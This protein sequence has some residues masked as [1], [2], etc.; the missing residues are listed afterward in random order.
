MATVTSSKR[1]LTHTSNTYES[2]GDVTIGG[3]LNINGTTTTIDTANL[4]VEDK[5]I[6]IGDV[7]SPSDTTADGGGIT[8]KGASDKTINWVN[9]TDSWTSN[10]RF[11]APNLTLTGL[12]AQNSEATALVVNGS[13]TVGTR[14]LGS[15][16]FNSTSFLTGNQTITLSGD[17]S[18]S[19][20]TSISVTVADDSHNHV[21]SNVDGLQSALDGKLGSSEKAAD[22]NLLDGIDSSAFLRS[23]A[24]DTATGQLTF[25][26][27]IIASEGL[28]GATGNSAPDRRIW[29]VSTT[30]NDWGIFY[31]EGN[32]DAIEFKSSGNVNAKIN[33]D[34]GK[35]Y[36]EGSNLVWHGGNDGSG[37][38]LDADLLDG[39]QG[40]KFLKSTTNPNTAGSGMADTTLSIGDSGS[41]YAFVQSH[42]GK[43]LRLNPAGN[44]VTIGSSN[45]TAWHSANDGSGS[46]LDADKLDGLHASS[47]AT[48][49]QGTKADNAL[50]KAGGTVTGDLTVNGKTILGNALSDK[51]VVH[52]HLGIGEDAY[53]KIAY[54]GK[55]AQ[56]SGSG[57]TT[58]QIVIDL[59]GTLAN[60]DMMYMEIDIYEYSSVGATK[61]IIGGHNWNSG[62]NSNTSTTQWYNVNVQVL[63]ALDKPIYF[64]RRNDGS[65]E[66]RCI[67]IG[68]TNSSWSYGTVHVSKVSGASSF[69][70][71]GIDWIGDWNVDQTTSGSYFTKNPTTNFNSGATL[72]TNGTISAAGGSFSGVVTAA[73]TSS[74][75]NSTKVATTAYVKNQGYLTTSGKAADSNLLDGLDL[76]T[77]TN[78]NANKV[79]RTDGNGYLHTG[80][81]STISGDRGTTAIS[82]I[83]ASND[84]YLRYYTPANFGAQIGSHISYN[85][86]TNKPSIPSLSGYAT[87]SYVGTQISNLI[88]GAPGALDT[89]NELAAAINDDASYASTIT[90]ALAGKLSTTGK[91]YDSDRLDNLNS[92]SFARSDAA[93]TFTQRMRFDNCNTNNHDNMAVSTSSLGGLEVYN[94]GS[95]NDAFMAFHTGGDFACYFGLDADSNKLSVGGWSMGAAKYEIYHSGNKPSLAT[96]GYTGAT[97][98]NYITNNNQLTNGAGYV[99]SSGNT[100]IGTDSDID[101]SGALVIDQLNMTDGVITSHTTRTLTLAN[102]GYTGATN[103]NNYSLPAGS[104][105]TRGGFKIGYSE[106]G[107]NYPVE[108]SAEKMFVNVPWSDTNTNTTYSAGTGISLSGTT[109][110]LTDTASKLSLSG[111][112][113]SG[114][115]VVNNY[116]IG[117][118]GLYSA[119]KYQAVWSMGTSYM[120][121]SSGGN[122]GSLY[123]LAWTHTNI[124][125][126]SKSGLS[127]QLLVMHN[128]TTRSAIGSGIWT[129]GTITTTGHGTSANWNTAY[130]WGNHASA[131]YVT[132]SGNTVIGTDSDINTS[133]ALVIDQL[134]MTDGV[135]QSHSTRTLTLANLGYTGATNANN[136]SLP[137]GSSSTRGGFKIGYPENGKYYPVELSS[138]KMYVHVP[139][140]DTNTDTNTTYSA[141]RGLDLS[142]TQF[143]LETDLRDSVSHIG[144]DG[145]D[146][147]QWS[148]N[149]YFRSVV[150][151]TERFRVNTTGIDVT[152]IATA[153]TFRT[154]TG[155]ADYNLI[156]RNNTSSTLYVQA[157]G[158]AST[159]PIASFRYGSTS[160]GQGTE[161]LA[162][163]RNS[164][165][166][167]NTKLGVGLT[168]PGSTLS[169][170]GGVA[171]GASYA[172]SS[173]PSNGMLIQGNVGIGTSSVS[174]YYALQ[175]NGS[176]QGSYKSFVI[177]HP[178]KEN[179]QLAH[180]C[181]EG[182]EIGV[183]FRGKSTSDTIVV[184]DYWDTLVDIDSMSVE[185]TAIGQGQDLFVSSIKENG[186]VVVG[187]NTD[188]P[189]NYYYVVYGERKD[190]NKLVV[191]FEIEENDDEEESIAESPNVVDTDSV[192]YINP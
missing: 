2:N 173:S 163:R 150:N 105:S 25:S 85:D 47:F 127:H 137:V 4:L 100:I 75:E 109:F 136:Y 77:G 90:T 72:E 129:D 99:T 19:G 38:G 151:G 168:N 69:Y 5:N 166:F 29:S 88:G 87:E 61:L 41:S 98:A 171:I 26:G 153:N 189:L 146:Y 119:T 64:G 148:L 167:N 111:G 31:N 23:N 174:G 7:S 177:D 157:A 63:G 149:S 141:G 36:A 185:L 17:V 181:L 160:A 191:E 96:L 114:N 80:W 68:E 133:G 158:S 46:G 101:T 27:N 172:S 65:N 66:R 113:I 125:G 187:T 140:T 182:P 57:T 128:G 58:G 24:N 28:F 178:T 21:I 161:V 118:V 82:R 9:S 186:D 11:S 56:W 39:L 52:G 93:D 152:G 15:N 165:Y 143:Q 42:G 45:G 169:V 106:N 33:L 116:G 55:N 44:A 76:H 51:A 156:T 131:G 164:S 159:Q 107:K 86:L 20:T 144:L 37:S 121:P 30:Y 130:G 32:P 22:S 103:A 94:N 1:Q 179:T 49:A 120:L 71:S 79:V 16:A 18:G 73:T 48:S 62:A 50:P 95:G 126:Q 43:A 170:S 192:E 147:I 91:A 53:P 8:L 3:N 112:T 59:P 108:T 83:Y 155:N 132:S 10:Q 123:G 60:Y 40:N 175:V 84:S 104:S 124:G 183:Y 102:L 74:S 139:W 115:I 92:T 78:N 81:I 138:E 154:D 14:E 13:N 188:E 142:G 162:V 110:S 122:S 176:I 184:A 190:I 134:N 145:G 117:N 70:T 35:I 54:P 12:S 67:A 97:N 34:D 6:I 180:A 89:L 135:I